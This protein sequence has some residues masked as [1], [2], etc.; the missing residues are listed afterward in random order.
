VEKSALRTELVSTSVAE[1]LPLPS[2]KNWSSPKYWPSPKKNSPPKNTLGVDD[3]ERA[4][5]SV[6]VLSTTSHTAADSDSVPES[7]VELVR[8]RPVVPSVR[9]PWSHGSSRSRMNTAPPVL[10]PSSVPVEVGA[11][12]LAPALAIAR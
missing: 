2:P 4:P 3:S 11:A 7:V 6:A 1:S 10:A 8:S 9:V 5:E 12:E